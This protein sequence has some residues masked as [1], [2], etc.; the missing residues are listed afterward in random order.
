MVFRYSRVN[1]SEIRPVLLPRMRS[2]LRPGAVVLFWA[3]LLISTPQAPAAGEV[4]VAVAANFTQAAKEIGAAFTEETGYQAVFSFGSTGQLFTQIGLDAPFEIFL[5]ADA[6][7][8][9]KAIEDGLALAGSRF[10]YAKGRLVLFSADRGL[11]DGA[12]TLERDGFHK[13]ALANPVT[14]PYGDAAVQVL[15]ALGV[16]DTLKGKFVLGNNIAQTFQFIDTG[17]AELG[18]VA[19]SQVMDRTDGSRWIVPERYYAPIAQDAVLLKRGANNAAARAFMRF[20]RGAGAQAIRD[21]Y[22]YGGGD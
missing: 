20:L 22:G 12:A 7:R 3:A 8:P 18:F 10:T 15:K 19:L 5:A 16:H 11:V 6:A 17:N 14:A 21:R 2:F 4:R 13:I 9:Q 1:I